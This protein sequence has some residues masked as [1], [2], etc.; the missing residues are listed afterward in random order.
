MHFSVEFW[1]GAAIAL[2]LGILGLAVAI[3]MDA[4]TVNEFRFVACCFLASAGILIYGVLLWQSNTALA[5]L[6]RIFLMVLLLV[7]VITSTGEAIRWAYSRHVRTVATEPAPPI[8]TETDERAPT[9]LDLFNTDFPDFMKVSS[10]MTLTREADGALI[11]IKRQAY[12]DFEA[13][14]KFVG[15]YISEPSPDETFKICQT[16]ADAVPRAIVDLTIAHKAW[17]GREEQ[18]DSSENLIF[19]GRMFL[20]YE[21]RPPL[22]ITQKADLTNI[23]KAKGYDVQFRGL[24]YEG[25]KTADWYNKHGFPKPL[26][27]LQ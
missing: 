2:C 5:A 17:G 15:F 19:S 22:S 16:L 23:Y 14:T 27:K 6:P 12:L 26:P 8:N 18:G 21:G 13:K 24:S 9:L 25:D 11:H 7:V 1:V 3:G 20:Y 4:K 10:D